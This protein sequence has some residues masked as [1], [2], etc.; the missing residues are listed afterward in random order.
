[1]VTSKPKLFALTNGKSLIIR[2]NIVGFRGQAER[3]TFVEWAINSLRNKSEM[4]LFVDY[5]TSSISVAQFSRALFDL[6]SMETSP[7]GI[8]NLASPMVSNKREFIVEIAKQ[9]GFS[10]EKAKD[11]SVAGLTSQRANSL[12]LDVTKAETLLGYSLPSLA[13]VVK[14]LRDEYANAC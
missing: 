2:T 6:L 3:P 10:L 11:G 14:Q 8:L 4:T 7:C 9:F 5:Y 1:F 12:G 13:D